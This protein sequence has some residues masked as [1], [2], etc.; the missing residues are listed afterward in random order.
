MEDLIKLRELINSF[1]INEQDLK[2]ISNQKKKYSD[3]IKRIN[4]NIDLNYE[5]L[6]QT[7]IIVFTY[8]LDLYL[9]EDQS[10]IYKEIVININKK[11]IQIGNKK[12][13]IQFQDIY[14]EYLSIYFE[15]LYAEKDILNKS[16]Y[17][18]KYLGFN[19]IDKAKILLVIPS[20]VNKKTEYYMSV[21][22]RYMLLIDDIIDYEIDKRKNILTFVTTTFQ[23]DYLVYFPLYQYLY[24]I[25][26]KSQIVEDIYSMN[27][28][29]SKHYFTNEG[30]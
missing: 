5:V 21:F 12:F 6:F 27:N 18:K 7:L 3:I 13:G 19:A 26:E 11:I 22:F 30:F 23:G 9:D 4:P 20:I 8:Y 2:V 1:I 29:M 16:D 17:R 28:Y 15:Y 10:S 24:E 14:H 25:L